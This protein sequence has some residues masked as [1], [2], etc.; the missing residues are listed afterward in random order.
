MSEKSKLGVWQGGR[1]ID[2]HS[3][4]VRIRARGEWYGYRY[5][6]RYVMEKHIGRRL[7]KD[8]QVHHKNGIKTDNRIENLELISSNSKHQ[9]THIKQRDEFGRFVKA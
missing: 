2:K 5:E 3:G 1:F 8:E 9:S 4:Y 7:T 6:H